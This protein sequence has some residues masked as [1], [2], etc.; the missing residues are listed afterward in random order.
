MREVRRECPRG[1]SEK[2]EVAKGQRWERP[3]G[4]MVFYDVECEQKHDGAMTLWTAIVFLYATMS[5]LVEGAT[6]FDSGYSLF[7]GKTK[8]EFWAFLNGLGVGNVYCFAFNGNKFDHL[9]MFDGARSGND[10]IVGPGSFVGGNVIVGNVNCVLKDLCNYISYTT[11]EKLGEQLN[12]PKLVGASAKATNI[13]YCARDSVILCK[14]WFEIVLK[15]FEPVVGVLCEDVHSLVLFTSQAQIAYYFMI[16]NV[17]N[18]YGM[19]LSFFDYCVSAYFGARIDSMMFGQY[20]ERDVALW[21]ITSMYPAG[22]NNK[23]PVGV[24]WFEKRFEFGDLL[25]APFIC[26]ARLVKRSN[27]S[28]D[29]CFGIL[30]VHYPSGIVYTSYGDVTGVYTCVDLFNAIEDG[31]DI[32]WTRDFVRWPM[33]TDQ[34]SEK[35]RKWFAIKCSHPKDS[36]LYWF[37]KQVLNASIG[38]FAIRPRD[39]CRKPVQVNWFAMGW[40]R[41]QLVLMKKVMWRAKVEWPLYGDT[42]SVVLL[43]SDM[44]RFLKCLPEVSKGVL[45]NCYQLS[46]DVET[47]SNFICV[48]AKKLFIMK[49]KI[50][51]KGHAKSYLDKEFFRDCCLRPGFTVK[52][53]PTRVVRVRDGFVKSSVSLFVPCERVCRV[54]VPEYK[55]KIGNCFVNK[56]IVVPYM[57]VNL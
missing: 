39:V 44:R 28:L 29:A 48:L 20:L 53:R 46:G 9:Y 54:V 2:I 25:D 5:F 4:A 42:D 57:R 36:V 40:A 33:W 6:F 38:V 51:A 15:M 13:L 50:S 7:V 31:W 41:R 56:F 37:A 1:V 52:D 19:D 55:L 26:R 23:L 21:D 12:C 30:P 8:E 32:K 11:I 43:D 14:S 24:P 45:G 17:D 10:L 49:G 16:D 3:E 47:K 35:Y 27:L 22:M 34:I 18:L